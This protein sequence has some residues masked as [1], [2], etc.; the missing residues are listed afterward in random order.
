MRANPA[1]VPWAAVRFD[2]VD[3][4]DVTGVSREESSGIG[5]RGGMPTLAGQFRGSVAE[6]KRT[7]ALSAII[8]P[9]HDY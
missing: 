3:A 5:I 7:G 4:A 1:G 9:R 6:I 2:P 8:R